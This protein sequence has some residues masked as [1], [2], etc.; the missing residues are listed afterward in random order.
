[1]IIYVYIYTYI[2]VGFFYTRIRFTSIK[3]LFIYVFY[4]TYL[5]KYI[6]VYICIYNRYTGVESSIIHALDIHALFSAVVGYPSPDKEEENLGIDI[7]MHGYTY[8]YIFK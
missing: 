1:M 6:Y 7:F 5:Y 4:Y 3:F 8:K 2:Y